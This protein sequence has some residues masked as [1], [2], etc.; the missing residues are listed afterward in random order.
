MRVDTTKIKKGST[1]LTPECYQLINEI[2]QCTDSTELLKYL[3]KVKVW[4]YGKC[5]LYHWIKILDRFDEILHVAAKR[6]NGNEYM[7]QC[8]VSFLEHV[9]KILYFYCSVFD[10]FH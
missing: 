4:V 9:R 6:L 2:S 3:E 10:Y 7:L 5:E 8:D 1:E